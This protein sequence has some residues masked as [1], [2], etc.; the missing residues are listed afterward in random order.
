M[1]LLRGR[2]NCAQRTLPM[3]CMGIRDGGVEEMVT[4]CR[5]GYMSSLQLGFMG[6]SQQQMHAQFRVYG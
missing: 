4:R 2:S 6:T 5:T 1:W 3:L